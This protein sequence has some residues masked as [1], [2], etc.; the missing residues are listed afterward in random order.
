ML[1]FCLERIGGKGLG[2]GVGG[3]TLFIVYFIVCSVPVI[4]C[5]CAQNVE[6]L[7]VCLSLSVFSCASDIPMMFCTKVKQSFS[8]PTEKRMKTDQLLDSAG[9]FCPLDRAVFLLELTTAGRTSLAL[10]SVTNK[11][12]C[13]NYALCV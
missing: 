9:F 2:W 5:R 6:V 7:C 1:L 11:K 8:Q 10:Q 3:R 4:S 12:M 13:Y